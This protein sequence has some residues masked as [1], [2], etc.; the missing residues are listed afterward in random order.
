M[1]TSFVENTALMFWEDVGT[2]PPYP[3][4]LEDWF[5]FVYPLTVERLPDLT[6][7]AINAWAQV[8]HSAYS[9]SGSPIRALRGCLLPGETGIIFVDASDSENE[10]R[11][12]IAHELAHFICDYHLPR[13][14][15]VRL[16]GKNIIAV[17]DGKRK[18]TQEERLDGAIVDVPLRMP[19]HLM[20]R[21]EK[22]VPSNTILSIEDR[23][24]R[25][26]LELLAPRDLLRQR[27]RQSDI[28]TEYHTRFTYLATILSTDYGLPDEIDSFYA[29]WLLNQWGE[30]TFRD[31]LFDEA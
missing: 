4:N 3:R 12:T 16:L 11:F 17:L 14:R 23:A 2:V 31:W 13:V 6:I 21:P 27:M 26:A 28:P 1:N 5:P 25:L 9:F 7:G 24:D 29:R 15:A 22:G 19:G 10:Q 20:E 18:P 8:H 30:P